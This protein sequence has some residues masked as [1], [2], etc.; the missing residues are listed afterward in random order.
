MVWETWP[1]T[2]PGTAVGIAVYAAGASGNVAPIAVISGDRTRLED[3]AII[4]PAAIY[5]TDVGDEDS[6]SSPPRIMVYPADSNGNVAPIVT[7]GGDKTGLT[8]PNGIA[9]NPAGREIYVIN[10]GSQIR[11]EDTMV[12][13]SPGANG[14]ITP[15]ATIGSVGDPQGIAVDSGKIYVT[16]LQQL[17]S[18]QLRARFESPVRRA[19]QFILPMPTVKT[20]AHW[21][22][23]WSTYRSGQPSRCNG[24]Q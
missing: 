1:T 8:L 5:V 24:W 20:P 13:Y 14:N 11:A 3:H 22:D 17:G 18:K 19:L 2:T 16:N 6:S 10:D 12:V 4:Q 15:V 7:I 9:V 23:S 21:R